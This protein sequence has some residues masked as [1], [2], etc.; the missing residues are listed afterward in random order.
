MGATEPRPS[1]ARFVRLDTKMAMK[2]NRS[3][4]EVLTSV[5]LLSLLPI[6]NAMREVIIEQDLTVCLFRGI[7][8]MLCAD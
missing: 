1:S 5:G 8:D 6:A 3:V 2:V 4:F 7:T